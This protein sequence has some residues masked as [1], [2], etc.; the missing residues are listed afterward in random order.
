MPKFSTAT[1]QIFYSK[2]LFGFIRRMASMTSCLT[3][4]S[5][6]CFI[7]ILSLSLQCLLNISNLKQNGV[8]SLFID[9]LIILLPGF[10][11]QYWTHTSCSIDSLCFRDLFFWALALWI[12]DSTHTRTASQASHHAWR[13][14]LILAKS[15]GWVS[16]PI[17]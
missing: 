10:P 6:H 8:S 11:S 17:A 12:W 1:S 13:V 16:L 14:A 3:H 9:L 5:I 15:P 4:I 7:W 2:S